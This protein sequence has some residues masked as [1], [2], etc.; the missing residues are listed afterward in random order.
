LNRKKNTAWLKSEA[1][2]LGFQHIGISKAE[3]LDEEAPRLEAWLNNNYQGKM[4]Y[5]ENWFDKRL[6]PAKLVVGAKSVISLSYNYCSKEKQQ[7]SDAPKVSMYAYGND[8]HLVLKEKL[9]EFIH[10]IRGEI[11]EINGR[12]F[13]DSAPVMEKAWAAKSGIGWIGKHTNLINQKNG[14]YFF[15]AELIVDLP[16]TPDSPATSHCGTCTK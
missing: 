7:D 5:M 11:G 1:I 9:K 12:A 6:D 2:R 3:R 13:T 10:N 16:L 4:G 15:L 14:S 8:Y